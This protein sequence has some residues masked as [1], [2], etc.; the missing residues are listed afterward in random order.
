MTLCFN[1][2]DY[3][4]GEVVQRKRTPAFGSWGEPLVYD[5]QKLRESST[6][7]AVRQ[8]RAE[9]SNWK[10]DENEILLSPER[11]ENFPE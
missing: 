2:T 8:C 10:P 1:R 11:S 4:N 9:L 5:L 3:K 7:E 6:K